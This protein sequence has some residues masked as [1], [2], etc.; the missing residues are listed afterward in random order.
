MFFGNR[1]I[2][3]VLG[4]IGI[5]GVANFGVLRAFREY[6][7][8]VRKIISTGL[9]SVAALQYAAGMDPFSLVNSIT[10]FFIRHEKEL[11][12][13]GKIGGIEDGIATRGFSYFLRARLFC[14]SNVRR[15]SILTWDKLD[16]I[17]KDHF[18]SIEGNSSEVKVAV[19]AIDLENDSEVL[20]EKENNIERLKVS[21]SFPGILPPV[22]IDGKRYINSSLFC[23]LPLG[24]IS[25]ND[26]PIVAVDIPSKV[27]Q[28]RIR[29]LI[30]VMSYA[31]EARSCRMK[32]IMLQKADHIITL[33]NLEGF[34]WGD[35]IHTPRLVQQA[36]RE[37]S[38]LIANTGL[39]LKTEMG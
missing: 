11:W 33:D 19:S 3:L 29:S 26:R 39:E 30:D 4:G 13:L 6:R 23:E 10:R 16:T 18:S 31:D 2:T 20:L 22:E 32:E 36:Y 28:P 8:P 24:T 37:T 9:S 35:F 17:L 34:H 27:Q 25:D 1:D 12:G 14:K 15:I 5:K 7:V 38:E 21:L